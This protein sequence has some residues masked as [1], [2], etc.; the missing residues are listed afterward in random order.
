M[1][2]DTQTAKESNDQVERRNKELQTLRDETKF[3]RSLVDKLKEQNDSLAKDLTVQ[4]NTAEELRRKLEDAQKSKTK[5]EKDVMAAEGLH[6]ELVSRLH[7]DDRQRVSALNRLRRPHQ[8]H[9]PSSNDSPD[10]NED[11]STAHSSE[12]LLPIRVSETFAPRQVAKSPSE[13]YLLSLQPNLNV[14]D[15][16]SDS[17]SSVFH[18]DGPTAIDIFP[19]R[20]PN[21]IDERGRIRA[22]RRESGKRSRGTSSASLNVGIGAS[23]V[24]DK[25]VEAARENGGSHNAP[26]SDNVPML[27]LHRAPWIDSLS[28]TLQRSSSTQTFAQVLSSELGKAPGIVAFRDEADVLKGGG[29]AASDV[30]SLE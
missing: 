12:A 5:L 30:I 3:L 26:T 15:S 24:H 19:N 10:P 11:S 14:S 17:E 9:Y 8:Y 18:A 1:M 22:A 6:W 2:C 28:P 16:D 4:V 20:P 25:G 7:V 21:G 27:A 13:S 23:S 29:N